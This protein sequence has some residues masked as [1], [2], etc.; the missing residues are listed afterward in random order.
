MA[1]T[2]IGKDL[3]DDTTRELLADYAHRAWSGWMEYLFDRS[4]TDPH[5]GQVTIPA[6]LANRWKRQMGTPYE[7][8][9]PNEQESDRQQAD[10]I[11]EILR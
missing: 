9:P 2:A 11:L 3:A 8:L 1:M 10:T 4:F 5:T 7:R 6:A